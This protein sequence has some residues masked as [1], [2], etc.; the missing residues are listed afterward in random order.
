M[1][2]PHRL[3]V[4]A[5]REVVDEY[6]NPT[7]RLDYGPGAARREIWG[8]L[9]PVVSREEPAAGRHSV[10]TLWRLF[11]FSPLGARERAEWR[12]LVLDVEGEPAMWAP[13]FG[14]THYEAT[15]RRVEG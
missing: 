15:L 7:P 12:G 8:H 9:Q 3:I 1:Q 14:R 13:R 5:P 4:V 11:T 6:D 10:I 2:L